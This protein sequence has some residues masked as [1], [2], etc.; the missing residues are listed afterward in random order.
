MHSP[1][2]NPMFGRELGDDFDP[3]VVLGGSLLAAMKKA[4]MDPPEWKSQQHLLEAANQLVVY[5]TRVLQL[6]QDTSAKNN[7]AWFAI[8][9]NLH[10]TMS[11]RSTHLSS[12][13]G[14]EQLFDIVPLDRFYQDQE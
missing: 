7:D 3:L 9:M 11:N 10:A 13:K 1:E 12:V 8:L 4:R 6:G 14:I 5:A 2:V